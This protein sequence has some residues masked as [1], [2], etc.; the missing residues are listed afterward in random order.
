MS[1]TTLDLPDSIKREAERLAE[2]DGVSLNKW[3]SNAV[4]QR[5]GAAETAAEF[6]K[7]RGAGG[8]AERLRAF[9][10]R[11]P[12]RGPDVEEQTS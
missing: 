7:R 9:L 2:Q 6:F 5:I 10:A 4:V 11:V 1:L 3:I 12:D 8:S